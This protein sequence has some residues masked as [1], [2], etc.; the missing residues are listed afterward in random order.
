MIVYTDEETPVNPL[1]HRYRPIDGQS[2]PSCHSH[3]RGGPMHIEVID[4]V[5]ILPTCHA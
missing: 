3:L 1:P 5:E 2:C 4:A